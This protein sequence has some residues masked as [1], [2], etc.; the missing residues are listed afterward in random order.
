MV[1]Y[2]SHDNPP[3]PQ[4]AAGMPVGFFVGSSVSSRSNAILDAWQNVPES[5]RAVVDR[6]LLPDETPV[7][8]FESDLDTRLNYAQGLLVLT[9]RRL[10]SVEPDREAPIAEQ[11]TP[12]T[13][14]CRDWLLAA[15]LTLRAKEQGGAGALELVGPD[16][17]LGEWRYTPTHTAAAH[18]L[19][20]RFKALRDGESI[21][22]VNG[23]ASSESLC[24]SCGLPVSEEYMLCPTCAAGAAIRPA[25]SLFRLAR[26]A[27]HRI[28]MAL[29]G[30]LLLTA[31]SYG[32]DW[33]RPT[34]PSRFSTTSSSP[35]RKRRD[36]QL[37]ACI[38]WYLAAMAGASFWTWLLTWGQDLRAGLGQR[39]DRR[40]SAQPRPTPTCSGC[41][42]SSSAASGPAT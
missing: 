31:A 15:G 18:R 33:C 6:H 37:L 14:K 35:T 17:R 24:P 36:G 23:D 19:A 40:R 13:L 11:N 25:R 7:A 21:V 20:D 12:P 22:E 42:W 32:C 38:P 4:P 27:R 1:Q 16:C 8:W 9:D 28:G 5:L 2:G 41:R 3:L 26:F 10:V 34:L 29:L 30:L 39:A